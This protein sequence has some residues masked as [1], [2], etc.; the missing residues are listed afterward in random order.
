[1]GG[2]RG[3]PLTSADTNKSALVSNSSQ[4]AGNGATCSLLQWKWMADWLKDVWCYLK[5]ITWTFTFCLCLLCT[6]MN[7]WVMSGLPYEV[8]CNKLM[9]EDTYSIGIWWTTVP[10]SQW[11][12]IKHRLKN[13]KITSRPWYRLAP[14]PNPSFQIGLL[15]QEQNSDWLGE[16]LV[17]KKP[18]SELRI[19]LRSSSASIKLRQHLL[20]FYFRVGRIRLCL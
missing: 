5:S 20:L 4:G 8:I 16:S 13:W 19:G 15:V 2:I 3:S 1:M 11:G 7:I 9:N 14:P 18:V 17:K 12:S 6:E 10:K